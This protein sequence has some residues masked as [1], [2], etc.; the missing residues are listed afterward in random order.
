MH[1]GSLLVAHVQGA[2]GFAAG[3][4][5]VV[6]IFGRG[7]VLDAFVV[8]ADVSFFPAEELEHEDNEEDF[9][10]NFT[11]LGFDN[12]PDFFVL[13]IKDLAHEFFVL[14]ES[15]FGAG[16]KVRREIDELGGGVLARREEE[17]FEGVWEGEDFVLLHTFNWNFLIWYLIDYF[18]WTF[19]NAIHWICYLVMNWSHFL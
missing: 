13:W 7:V 2:G 19:A 1:D 16:G 10:V 9:G 8:A 6:I 11:V 14:V 15:E 3:R 5:E 4:G 12:P 17:V 18:K